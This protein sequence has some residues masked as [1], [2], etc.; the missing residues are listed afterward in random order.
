ML[1]QS[2]VTLQCLPKGQVAV[3]NSNTV[4]QAAAAKQI[5]GGYTCAV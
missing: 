3:N 1:E 2:I 4:P 5:P